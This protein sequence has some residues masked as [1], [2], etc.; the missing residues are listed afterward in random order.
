[1]AIGS[2]NSSMNTKIQEDIESLQNPEFKQ[3]SSRSNI[4]SKESNATILG[5]IKK[6]FTD[7]KSHAFNDP[8]NNLTST[9]TGKALDAYQG[10]VLNDK[11]G[12]V[13]SFYEFGYVTINKSDPT[14]AGFDVTN[15]IGK[16]G[17]LVASVSI[18]V[19]GTLEVYSI[20]IPAWL[21]T[22]GDGR[23]FSSGHAFTTSSMFGMTVQFK[24]NRINFTQCY[25]DGV[26]TIPEYMYLQ[27]LG[28]L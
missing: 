23:H 16:Y 10:K 24:N 3:A 28:Q 2:T 5:K 27:Y 19:N 20:I 25:N 17:F 21:L 1:M 6:Y 22:G 26:D 4:N 9:T 7:L 11:I 13:F 15:Y 14:S 8:V 18:P 12:N